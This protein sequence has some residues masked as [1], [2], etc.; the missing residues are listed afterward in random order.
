MFSFFETTNRCFESKWPL[1]LHILD[2]SLKCPAELGQWA[3]LP[4]CTPHIYMLQNL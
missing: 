1:N 3:A 2:S 4:T